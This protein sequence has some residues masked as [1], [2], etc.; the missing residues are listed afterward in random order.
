M[1]NGG[2]DRG[3]AGIAVDIKGGGAGGGGVSYGGEIN[4]GPGPVGRG[5]RPDGGAVTLSGD[6][7]DGADPGG[8]IVL[9]SNTGG[10]TTFSGTAKVLNTGSSSRRSPPRQPFGSTLSFTNGGLDIAATSGAGLDA[11]SGGTIYRRSGPPTRSHG[12]RPRAAAPEQRHRGQRR[13]AASVSSNGAANGILL[14]NTANLNGK[15]VV[16]GNGGTCT[17][18]ASCTGGAIQNSTGAGI[19]LKSVTGGVS[20]TRIAVTSGDDDGIRATTVN[21]LDLADSIVTNNGNNHAGGRHGGARPGLPQRDRHAAD[22]AH[23]GVGL[24]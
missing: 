22:P 13:D 18:A 9:I 20:L 3:A 17:S 6:I 23:D 4:D 1:V 15:L 2:H 14:D 19:S 7:A 24:G 16:T 10:T 21:D 5:H 8:G 12:N 11:L